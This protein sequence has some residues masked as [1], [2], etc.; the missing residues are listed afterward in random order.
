MDNKK[1]TNRINLISWIFFIEV[2]HERS[3]T[4]KQIDI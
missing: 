1:I 3:Y 2:E 4:G